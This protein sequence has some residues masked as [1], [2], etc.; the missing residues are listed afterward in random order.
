MTAKQLRVAECLDGVGRKAP[1]GGMQLL[2]HL[3]LLHH[4]RAVSTGRPAMIQRVSALL[5][6][7][8]DV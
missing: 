4:R 5:F 3:L 8:P 2:T 1:A 6:L 7:N